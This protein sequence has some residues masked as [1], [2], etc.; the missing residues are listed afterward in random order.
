[1]GGSPYRD[2]LDIDPLTETPGRDWSL[3]GASVQGPQTETPQHRPPGQ[4]PPLEGTWDQGQRPPR[5]KTGPD[6]QIVSDIKQ[7]TPCEQNDWHT[8]LKILP[9]PRLRLR[10][11]KIQ[12]YVDH[13]SNLCCPLVDITQTFR[14]H[15]AQAE[16]VTIVTVN[17]PIIWQD[18]QN[19]VIPWV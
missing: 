2:P 10:V 16:D 18:A 12:Y 11:V 15:W 14:Y 6:S 7:R 3:S 17:V 8:L 5:K 9:C 13:V 19:I 1:M 4:R